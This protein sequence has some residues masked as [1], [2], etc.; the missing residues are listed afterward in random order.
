MLY[1]CVLQP[2]LFRL[3]ASDPERAHELVMHALRNMNRAPLAAAMLAGGPLVHDRRLHQRLFGLTFPNPVGLAAGFDKN[4]LALPALAALGFGFI[5]AG[6]ITYHPQPGNPRPRVLRLP[7]QQAMINRMGF[8]NDGA[9]VVARRLA[10][11][12]RLPVPLGIS[13]GKSKVTP[14]EQAVEDYRASLRLLQPYAGY[15]AVNVSSPNTPGLRALQEREQ[16][17]TLLR[18]LVAESAVIA[19]RAGRPRA[20][21][22]VKVAPDL[23][24]QALDELLDV[25]TARGVDGIIAVNTTVARPAGVRGGRSSHA[26]FEGGLSGRPL[27]ARAVEV[28]RHIY[29]RT[30][31]SLPLI[32]V[33]GIFT[34]AD[35]YAMIRAGASVVQVYTGMIYEGPAI[36]RRINRGLLRLMTADGVRSLD[37]VRGREEKA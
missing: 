3:T 9:A 6:T 12:P 32:G 34:A 4:A 7:E 19:A 24:E 18:V 23:T 2:A 20:P 31:G 17:D 5:E 25:C 10:R 27:H 22:L 8:N 36:A 16:V 26:T 28:V 21:L 30:G 35:A 1:E 29:S 37:E 33:G 15:I 11:T 14:L 13:L